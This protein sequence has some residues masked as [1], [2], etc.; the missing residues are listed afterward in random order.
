MCHDRLLID[1]YS[2]V[3]KAGGVQ[4]DSKPKASRDTHP[5]RPQQRLPNTLADQIEA[6][7]NTAV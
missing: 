1:K 6:R 7:R 5:R 2:K 3:E 4:G